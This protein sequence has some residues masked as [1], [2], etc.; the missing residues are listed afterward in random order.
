VFGKDEVISVF[1]E[2]YD[3]SVPSSHAVDVKVSVLPLGGTIP[4][5]TA[6]E[7]REMEASSTLRV[8]GYKA[9]IPAKDLAPGD[10]VLRLEAA[11]RAGNHTAVRE[12]PFT[13][14]PLAPGFSR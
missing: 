1:T 2:I 11:S 9:E 3:R 13:I 8:Q 12:V 6:T 10:Y 14:R 4:V 7:T 5:F